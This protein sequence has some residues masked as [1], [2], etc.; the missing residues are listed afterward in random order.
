MAQYSLKEI[1]SRLGNDSIIIDRLIEAIPT[2]I[3]KLGT[4]GGPAAAPKQLAQKSKNSKPD[5]NKSSNAQKAAK[6]EK[7][8]KNNKDNAKSKK[9]KTVDVKKEE[10]DNE[11]E[12]LDNDAIEFN[13]NE[14]EEVTDKPVVDIKKKEELREQLKKMIESKRQERKAEDPKKVAKKR[15]S[16]TKDKKKEKEDKKRKIN[17][18]IVPERV[19]VN[20]AEL[21]KN[22]SIKS[23][24]SIVENAPISFSK[25]E[26]EGVQYKK[27][28][29]STAHNLLQKVES[30]KSKIEKV[31]QE[32]KEKASALI[33][34][35]NWKKALQ[36]ANG[37]KVKDDPKLLK[38]TIKRQQQI[39]NKSSKEWSD[40]KTKVKDDEATKQSKRTAN[41]Q[42]R[43][44]AKKNKRLGIKPKKEAFKP[45]SGGNKF[46]GKNKK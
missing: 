32:D 34:K 21:F 29:P 46:K 5:N 36:L 35:N 1:E 25:F 16:K 22:S 26:F 8:N 10:S 27:K 19:V 44:D 28:G 40:R 37:E 45:K 31:M 23:A 30:E 43:I 6:E 24:D 4:S 42:K 11:D 38:K 3:Y 13:E 15:E 12:D 33:E 14:Q 9:R 18:T 7:K 17:T 41:L 39:K 20:E 2:N